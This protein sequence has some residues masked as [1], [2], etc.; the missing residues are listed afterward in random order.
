M[1]IKAITVLPSIYPLPWKVLRVLFASWWKQSHLT[2]D[3]NGELATLCS[4]SNE[5]ASSPARVCQFD[6]HSIYDTSYDI[7]VLYHVPVMFIHYLLYVIH[8]FK[9]VLY[10]KHHI[11]YSDYWSTLLVLDYRPRSTS[12]YSIAV[13]LP[14]DSIIIYE[15]LTRVSHRIPRFIRAHLSK[16]VPFPHPNIEQAIV[17]I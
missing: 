11:W 7:R 3:N 9:C 10:V 12:K 8:R 17:T 16:L 15:A 2:N 5:P 14:V 4:N 6:M 1:M 13:K